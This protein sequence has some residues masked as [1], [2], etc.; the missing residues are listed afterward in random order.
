MWNIAAGASFGSHN[1]YGVRKASRAQQPSRLDVP[2]RVRV[3]RAARPPLDPERHNAPG[4][5]TTQDSA[6]NSQSRIAVDHDRTQSDLDV[7]GECPGMKVTFIGNH[8]PT[9]LLSTSGQRS[10]HQDLLRGSGG[11]RH[12]TS[13]SSKGH[14]SDL[15]DRH[16]QLEAAA[17]AGLNSGFTTSLF[18]PL[19]TA[20]VD[21]F[22]STA[23]PFD[24]K[25]SFMLK[26]CEFAPIEDDRSTLIERPH[27]Y[28]RHH[29]P[30]SLAGI[31]QQ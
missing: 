4:R 31:I 12:A 1:L 11:I 22:L 17:V 26:F 28:A 8:Q 3:L 19:E 15:N 9:S 21:P 24:R 7:V 20:L 5:S 30:N 27:S 29:V 13:P 6:S 16:R 23:V 10:R 2:G 14:S 18:S 25:K